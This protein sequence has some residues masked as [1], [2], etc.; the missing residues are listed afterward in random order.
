M[1]KKLVLITAVIL[2]V[3]AF[4]LTRTRKAAMPSDFR[5]AV[6]S[7][8]AAGQLQNAVP[9]DQQSTAIDTSMII[10]QAVTP[11][12]ETARQTLDRLGT[13]LSEMQ[14]KYSASGLAERMAMQP[15]LS[16]LSREYTV[17]QERLLLQYKTCSSA[18]SGK[19]MAKGLHP[20]DSFRDSKS[21]YGKSN[22]ASKDSDSLNALTKLKA[23]T[24]AQGATPYEVLK[25]IFEKGTPV[26][27]K[28]LTGWHAGRIVYSQTPNLF[29]AGLLV[30]KR[31]LANPD[32][33]PLFQ[34]KMEFK[35]Y[36]LL[37]AGQADFY[38]NMTPDVISDVSRSM[39]SGSWAL[40]FPAAEG[41]LN[42]DGGKA[43]IQYR[44]IE[45]YIFE[46]WVTYD[47]AGKITGGAY[48]YYFLD[49]TPPACRAL[50][51]PA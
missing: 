22:A 50:P 9:A 41:I 44:K 21:E 4:A 34:D 5:D 42:S 36:P 26:V 31:A 17:C 35:V 18:A 43:V 23:D 30:G 29:E 1:N 3:G 45:G 13:E 14:I 10:P 37:H 46:Q 20:Y 51:K 49:V 2:A 19:T 16:D 11:K 7:E 8:G 47:T 6:G 28:D 33:G 15:A 40:S 27:E 32:G 38:D 12:V 39:T 24:G 25:N 48:T